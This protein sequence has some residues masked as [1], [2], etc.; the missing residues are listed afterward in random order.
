[1]DELPQINLPPNNS[2]S[3][4]SNNDPILSSSSDHWLFQSPTLPLTPWRAE[5]LPLD[6]FLFTHGQTSQRPFMDSIPSQSTQI[7]QHSALPHRDGTF[8]ALQTSD[9][10]TVPPAAPVYWAF[11]SDPASDMTHYVVPGSNSRVSMPSMPSSSLGGL[12]HANSGIRGSALQT[13]SWPDW[14]S[15]TSTP[16]STVVRPFPSVG[17]PRTASESFSASLPSTIPTYPPQATSFLR[18]T[19]IP[20]SRMHRAPQS[21]SS[22]TLFESRE[23]ADIQSSAAERHRLAL[24]R[25]RRSTSAL[26]SR[27]GLT[28]TEA[29]VEGRRGTQAAED[30]E[31][32][33]STSRPNFSARQTEE[34]IA[35]HLQAIRG[36]TSRKLV[37]S[38]AALQSLETVEMC[39]LAENEKTCVICYNDYGVASPEGAVEVPTRLPLCKHI[40]GNLCIKKWLGD[41]DSCPY[42]RRRM[43]SE[44][45][46]LGIPARAFLNMMR[47]RGLPA[48]PWLSEE[49]MNSSSTRPIT[50]VEFQELFLHAARTTQRRPPPDDNA[51]QEQRRTRQRLNAA[52]PE[53]ALVPDDGGAQSHSTSDAPL[54]Q[55]PASFR[56]FVRPGENSSAAA[57]Q[58]V[59]DSSAFSLQQGRQFGFATGE[60]TAENGQAASARPTTRPADAAAPLVVNGSSLRGGSTPNPLLRS[61][62]MTPLAAVHPSPGAGTYNTSVLSTMDGSTQRPADADLPALGSSRMRPW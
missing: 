19:Q 31:S 41:S 18:A 33:A 62:R 47:V 38:K 53:E 17:R 12:A 21:Q 36:A 1:M 42:C 50:D 39:S 49:V 25:N 22:F 20:R 27:S 37:A 45:K 15:P 48:P 11:H 56:G 61:N 51:A 30:G 9:T 4:A 6:S 32:H 5:P 29:G 43:Q 16:L 60:R 55:V 13:R 58:T 35:R 8:G 26:H 14:E 2:R 28:N 57:Q 34:A 44:P 59:P 24:L 7:R 10:S 54:W 52:T 40:F 23:P 46:R 3:L